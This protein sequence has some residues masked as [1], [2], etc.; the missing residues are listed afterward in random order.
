MHD[1]RVIWNI[2]NIVSCKKGVAIQSKTGHAFIKQTMR[3]HKAIYGGELSAHHYFRDFAY[4]DSGMIPWLLVAELVS[5]SGLPLS[6]LVDSRFSSFPSSGETNFYVD[7][8]GEAIERV[9]IAYRAK[10]ISIDSTDGVSLVFN[11]WRLN[12]RGSNTEPLLRLNVE[13]RGDANGIQAKISDIA[14][15]IDGSMV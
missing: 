7:N 5:K 11:N 8:V 3:E 14:R 13:S 10:A 1:P 4:C 9:I 12:L 2:Q 15:I 6:A